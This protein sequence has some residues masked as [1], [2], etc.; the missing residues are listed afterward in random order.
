MSSPKS[1]SNF[2]T[3][4]FSCTSVANGLAKSSGIG[5]VQRE[6][7]PSSPVKAMKLEIG[8]Q[9]RPVTA[10]SGFVNLVTTVR[11]SLDQMRIWESAEDARY[12]PLGDHASS[13][14]G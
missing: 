2:S 4:L 12:R 7:E 5:L 1:S 13:L 3:R 11:V 6:K 10:P 9:A 8:D 14:M